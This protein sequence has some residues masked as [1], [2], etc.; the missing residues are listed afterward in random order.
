MI[1]HNGQVIDND[2]PDEAGTPGGLPVAAGADATPMSSGAGTTYTA[3]APA[4]ARTALGVPAIAA[5]M[6]LSGAQAMTGDLDAGGNQ[7][8]NLGAPAV[9]SDAATKAYVDALAAGLAPRGNVRVMSVG[10]TVLAAPGATV[11]GVAMAL[12]TP[13][14]VFA[15]FEQSYP[16]ESGLYEWNGAGVPATRTANM[17]TGSSA[18]AA[19]FFVEEGTYGDKG[20]LVTNDA[21]SD[22]VNTDTLVL[23]PFSISGL[24]AGAGLTMTGSTVD[25]GAGTGITVN[26]NDVAIDPAVVATLTGAQT[27][28]NKTL[29]SPRVGTSLNDTAGNELFKW[30]PIAAAVNELTVSNGDAGNGPALQATGDDTD[31]SVRIIPK[32]AGDAVITGDL[33]ATGGFRQTVGPFFV[34]LA[35]SQTDAGTKYG[36]SVGFEWVA[37]FAGSVMGASGQLD[38]AVAGAGESAKVQ[39]FKNGAL[40]HAA[41]DLDFTQAGAEVTDRVTAAKGAHAFVDGDRLKVV[42]DSTAITNTPK[43]VANLTVEC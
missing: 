17:A 8:S 22:V 15:A 41:L 7:L 20:F 2:V 21:G 43:L 27:L 35:A 11:N 26:A 42:Y 13:R 39:V 1:R 33:A 36:D 14:Q 40:L 37:Q 23:A 12:T 25:V 34:T 5:V 38:A 9:S 19:Y 6:L 16:P 30:N 3:R 4:A 29:T 24:V 31:I 28:T 10:N 32:G 18:R